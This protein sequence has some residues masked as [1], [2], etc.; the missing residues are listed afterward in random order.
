[1]FKIISWRIVNLPSVHSIFTWRGI[2]LN[3]SPSSLSRARASP[4]YLYKDLKSSQQRQPISVSGLSLD[5]RDVQIRLTH[6]ESAWEALLVVILALRDFGQ[7]LSEQKS[8]LK[9]KIFKD[10]VTSLP[11]TTSELD[12]VI[13]TETKSPGL[14]QEEGLLLEKITFTPLS[15]RPCRSSGDLLLS[16]VTNTEYTE[17]CIERCSIITLSL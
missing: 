13:C 6:Q 3:Q 8:S 10:Q 7:F 9:D 12:P 5:F 4:E 1:M 2:G 17:S 16:P 15:V 11:W 14:G